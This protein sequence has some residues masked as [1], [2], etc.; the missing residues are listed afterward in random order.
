MNASPLSMGLFRDSD[1]PLWHPLYKELRSVIAECAQMCRERGYRIADL[2]LQYAMSY[3]GA[4]TIVVGC[5]TP[6]EID[7]ALDQFRL[8][9]KTDAYAAPE[10]EISDTAVAN[11][12]TTLVLEDIDLVNQILAKL[13]PYHNHVWPSPP[14]DA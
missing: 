8:I 7:C 5:C 13:G 6:A 3:T 4:D 11:T 14:P 10:N 2:A 1:P 9:R 12:H